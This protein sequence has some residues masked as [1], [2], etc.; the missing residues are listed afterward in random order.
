MT[1]MK[2]PIE[3]FSNKTA[4]EQTMPVEK[5]IAEKDT[6]RDFEMDSCQ[7]PPKKRKPQEISEIDFPYVDIIEPESHHHSNKKRR[8]TNDD[9]GL[10]GFTD[11]DI[12][13]SRK[14]VAKRL[15][16]NLGLRNEDNRIENFITLNNGSPVFIKD[17]EN[18]KNFQVIGENSKGN[19][20]FSPSDPPQNVIEELSSLGIMRHDIDVDDLR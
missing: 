16:G 14:I 2:C 6:R 17:R 9:N 7:D 20:I 8:P 15:M 3:F 11:D 18:K 5:S 1:R 4:N 19:L 12:E 10:L 13:D